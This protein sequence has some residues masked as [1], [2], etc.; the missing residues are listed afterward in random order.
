FFA[1]ILPSMASFFLVGH[2]LA[3]DLPA[4]REFPQPALEFRALHGSMF[5]HFCPTVKGVATGWQPEARE[6]RARSVVEPIASGSVRQPHLRFGRFVKL[7]SRD[8]SRVLNTKR[9]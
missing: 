9:G 6:T 7:A 8:R 1:E 2:E 5:G 4:P 3:G